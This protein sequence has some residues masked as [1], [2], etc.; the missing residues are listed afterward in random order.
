MNDD[1][2]RLGVVL[3]QLGRGWRDKSRTTALPAEGPSAFEQVTRRG[4]DDLT[5][6]VERLETKLNGILLALAG[7]ILIDLYR[8]LVR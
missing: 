3:G 8:T 7:S 2:S 1:A 5:R 6:Q 4:L